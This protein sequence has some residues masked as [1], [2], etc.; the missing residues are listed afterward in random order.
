MI[1]GNPLTPYR[2]H[3]ASAASVRGAPR[4]GKLNP[5]SMHCTK[6]IGQLL[7]NLQKG[8]GQEYVKSSATI[9]EAVNKRC[10]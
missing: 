1:F 6:G 2:V 8:D 7:S 10:I 9:N 5:C 3:G 4:A